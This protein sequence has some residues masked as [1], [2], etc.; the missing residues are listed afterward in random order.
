MSWIFF[1]S[2][3]LVPIYFQCLLKCQI[4]VW[5]KS[6]KSFSSINYWT[7]KEFYCFLLT[8]LFELVLKEYS[9]SSTRCWFWIFWG[10]F[11]FWQLSSVS[12]LLRVTSWEQ[13]LPLLPTVF[14]VMLLKNRNTWCYLVWWFLSH[15][16]FLRIYQLCFIFTEILNDF[17]VARIQFH[18]SKIRHLIFLY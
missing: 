4:L 11:C 15:K 17:I 14:L 7:F 1:L 2:R 3:I 12:L 6:E 18:G 9:I 10:A 8:K 16:S 5:F 13:F